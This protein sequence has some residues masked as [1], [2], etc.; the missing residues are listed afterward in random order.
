[1][2]FLRTTALALTLAAPGLA[3]AADSQL[4]VFDWA[5]F[6]EPVIFQGYIDKHGDSPTFAFYG[7]D[8]EAFQKL[9]S[10]FRADVAQI[11]AAEEAKRLRLAEIIQDPAC[12]RLDELSPYLI[13]KVM[14]AH[15]GYGAYG[16]MSIAGVACHKGLTQPNPAEND[17]LRAEGDVICWWLDADGNRHGDLQE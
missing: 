3:M 17:R 9:S 7:D 16:E 15:L 12:A 10:G 1:M 14:T 6:E 8:D 13:D 2:T 11:L 4:T 5:G